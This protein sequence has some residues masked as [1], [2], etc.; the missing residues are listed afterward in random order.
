MSL[1]KAELI[2]AAPPPLMFFP[3]EFRIEHNDICKIF[4]KYE[5][6]IARSISYSKSAY[7]KDH[8]NNEVIFNANIVLESKGKVWYGDLDITKDS[9]HLSEIA[10]ELGENL[11]IL[12][13]SD[14]RWGKEKDDVKVL[15]ANAKVIIKPKM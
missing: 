15:I 8:P 6:G 2:V 3:S 12:N 9:D 10:T 7:R 1:G 13:E 4:V 5:L 11:Y 14:A